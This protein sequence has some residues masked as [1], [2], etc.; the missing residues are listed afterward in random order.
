VT[1]PTDGTMAEM[2]TA[3]ADALRGRTVDGVHIYDA[4]V[5]RDLGIDNEPIVRVTLLLDNPRPGLPTW[6][7]GTIRSLDD[8]SR[9][10]AWDLGI[11]DWLPIVHV[12]ARDAE[13]SGFPADSIARARS[14]AA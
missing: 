6:P 10:V 9:R 5:E 11:V 3:L 7:V 4:L 2:L 13:D 8:L 1:L 14:A 12:S